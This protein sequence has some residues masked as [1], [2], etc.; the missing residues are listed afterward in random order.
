MNQIN[1]FLFFIFLFTAC[2]PFG[3]NMPEHVLKS[4]GDNRQELEK[5][6]NHYQSDLQKQKAARFLI[7]NMSGHSGVNSASMEK[8]QPIYTEYVEISE[9]HNWERSSEWKRE[10]DAYWENKKKNINLSQFNKKQDIQTIKADWLIN[11]I[12]RSFKAWQENIYTQNDSFEDFCK[13]ILPYRFAEGLCLDDSRDVFYKRHAHLFDDPDKDFR[14]VTD[15]LHHIYK[16]L[17]H[18]DWAAASLPIYNAATFEQIKRGSCDDK[19]WYNC[20]MMSALGMAVAVDFVPEWGNRAGGHSW[21][22]LIVHGETHAFEPFWDDDRWKYKRIYN[23]ECFDLRWGKFRLPKVYRHTYEHHIEGPISD[24]LVAREDIPSLFKNPFMEDVS[25]QYFNA[26]DV[27]VKITEQIPENTD[28][29]YLCVFGTKEWQP[30]QWGKIAWNKKVTFKEIGKDIVY[31]PMFYKNGILTPAAPAFLLNQEGIYEELKCTNKRMPITVRNYTAYLYPEEIAESKHFLSGSCLVGCN[32][33]GETKVDTLYCMTDS[34]DTWANDI[35]LAS[36]SKYR[37]LRLIPAQD[38]VALCEISF[39]ER[40]VRDTPISPVQVSAGTIPL[41]A[42]E[43]IEMIT[44]NLSATG[45]TG[46]FTSQTDRNKGIWFDLGESC[47]ISA[48]SYIPYTKNYLSKDSEQ[49]LW[50][51]DNQWISAGGLV[52]STNFI[53]FEN[54]PEGTI[55]RVKMKSGV[56]DRIFTYKNGIIHWF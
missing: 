55:Y 51:W 41:I 18:F 8:L 1:F 12:D 45:F 34:M 33:L 36:P 40:S 31:L 48:F 23:N 46:A 56:N 47:T 4:A 11:E 50:Y 14:V 26:V 7:M 42:G 30:V 32:D 16:D 15:S 19:A 39:Y 6:L 54:I 49:E 53:T 2:S 22:S 3:N 5:V 24:K 9:K 13:Y 52:C 37:F 44:D 28:Y 38:T 25:S 20:L 17:M 29:C 21:N 10:I 43:Q 27:K 35:T